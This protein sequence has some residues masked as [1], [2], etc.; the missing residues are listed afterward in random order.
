MKRPTRLFLHTEMPTRRAL[1]LRAAERGDENWVLAGDWLTDEDART[2]DGMLEL[3]PPEDVEGTMRRL[4]E[5]EFDSLV[6]QTEYGLLP[7]ALIAA[8]RSLPGPTPF[9]AY[10][11]VNKWLCRRILSAAGVPV[12]RFGLASSEQDVRR[13]ADRFPLILKPVASTLGALVLR[14]DSAEQ[15]GAGVRALQSGLRTAPDVRRCT[16]FA[17]LAGFDLECEPTRDFL[18]EDFAEGAPFETD[19]LV[20]GEQIETFGA[21]EQVVTDGSRGFYIEGYLFP[22]ARPALEELTRRTIRA[23][24]LTDAGFSIEFRGDLVIEINA[25][26]GEDE[27]FPELFASGLGV[28]PILKWIRGDAT[29]S[30]VAGGHALAFRNCLDDAVVTSVPTSSAAMILARPGMRYFAPPHPDMQP[31][32]AY[33]LRSDAVDAHTAYA[34]ARASVDALQF[35]LEPAPSA[36]DASRR[37]R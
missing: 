14:V 32:L 6:I 3:P 30:R 23:V 11:C 5:V 7:G 34:A 9:A 18:V 15:I 33:A 24:G 31:H 25:R 12:P 28:P 21:T 2:F 20:F 17:A 29:P 10:A 35:T 13:F 4:R 27:G 16:A 1:A 8:E 22:I 26:L 37:P 19:G 36:E